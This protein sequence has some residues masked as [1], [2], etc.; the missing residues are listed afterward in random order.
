MLGQTKERYNSFS[1]NVNEGL[2]QSNVLDIAF[3]KYNFC[4]LSF[5]N[6]IQKFDGINFI[7]IPVQ[8]GLPDDKWVKFFSCGNGDLFISHSQGISKYEINSNKFKHFY[9]K[10]ITARTQPALIGEDSGI[11]YLLD[12][13]FIIEIDIQTLKLVAKTMID[14][15]ATYLHSKANTQISENLVDHKIAFFANS[16][17]LV[18]DL[19]KRIISS[20]SEPLA[21]K[22]IW[23]LYLNTENEVL[24][25]TNTSNTTFNIYNLASGKNR[26]VYKHKYSSDLTFR[27]NISSWQ[28]KTIVSVYNK[29]FEVDS[30]FQIK[31]EFVNFSNQPI[32]GNTSIHQIRE[33]NFGNLYLVTISDGFRKIVRNNYPIKYYGTEKKE[34]NYILSIFPDKKN[35]RILA[36]TSGSGLLVFDTLQRLVK[37]IKTLP[38]RNVGFSPNT[39][40]KNNNGDYVLFIFKEENLWVLNSNLTRLEPI[41]I[42]PFLPNKKTST[43]YFTNLLLQNKK[44]AVTHSEGR[45]FKTDLSNNKTKE[46]HLATGYLMSGFYHDSSIIIHNNDDLI[47]FDA[48]SFKE[49]KRI[50]FKNTGGVRCYTKDAANN[51]YVGSNKGVFKINSSGKVLLHLNKDNGLPD[52][53]IYAMIFDNDGFLWCSS[54]KGI[55]KINSDNSILQLKKEDGLQENEF[56]TNIV[57]KTE[58]GEVF[59][60]GVNGV[61]SFYPAAINRVKEKVNLLITGIKV[62]NKEA[63]TDTAVWNIDR[64]DLPHDQNTLSIDFIAMANNNPGQYIYQYRMNGI[65]KEWIQNTDLQTVRYFLPPGSYVFQVYASRFFNKDAKPLKEIR[66]TIHP[67][68][69]QTWWFRTIAALLI[70]GIIVYLVYQY[71]HRKYMQKISELQTKQKVQNEKD[72]ISRELHDD[73]GTTANMLMYNA[74]LLDEELKETEMHLIKE[75][76]KDASSDMLLSLRETVWTL[77]QET[78]SSED[79]WTRFKNFISKMQRT[80]SSKHFEIVE[81]ELPAKELT[82]NKALHV[83]RILQEAVNNAV[84]HADC[85]C[86]KCSYF[87]KD[88]CITF[89]VQDNGKGF[90]TGQSFTGSGLENMKH[91]SKESGINLQITSKRNNG[92]SIT[93]QL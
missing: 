86:I 33:D 85:T 6:G 35:N 48:A 41:N 57:A 1:F 38:R 16:T 52:E 72:R 88:D 19:K 90:D 84:K 83:I 71:N 80:Y 30:S 73:L 79:V 54:N 91:R 14:P 8:Q 63:F 65:D 18:W 75:K 3:D 51:I 81:I 29:L 55:F 61:S 82:Y 69:W 50:P 7:S 45:I 2:L 20:K 40:I 15:K 9:N 28:N 59:F 70:V 74:S 10:V 92:T 67:V 23:S 53:C 39:I 66:I 49:V 64:I 22:S 77:K 21:E 4:W 58:D 12:E 42:Y 17:F 60:G 89:E 93:L 76:I 62:N 5:A 44:E 43:Y 68:F 26:V 11:L 78:I 34:E 37:H 13:G 27:S 36:G 87:T 25:H 47:F 46:Y 56:N 32:A 24:Y 31:K